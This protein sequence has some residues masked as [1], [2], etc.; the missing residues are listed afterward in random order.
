MGAWGAR[1]FEN[2]DALDWVWELEESSDD[3]VVRAAFAA[4]HADVEVEAPEAS[5]ACAAAEVVAAAA[6]APAEWLPD[7]VTA[8]VAAHG[9]AVAGLR[10][11]ARAAVQ[12]IAEGSELQQLW[13]EAGGAEWDTGIA[14][15][16]GRLAQ[17]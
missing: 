3:S 2:D 7:E 14:D 1:S 12:R 11:E 10:G 5:C 9:S 15:L 8:W 16:L 6:G 13:A 17:A 4:V